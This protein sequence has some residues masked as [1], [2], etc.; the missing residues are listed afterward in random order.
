MNLKGT[1]N[2]GKLEV[3]KYMCDQNSQKEKKEM[4]KEVIADFLSK[5][6]R[7][8]KLTVL[9]SVNLQQKKYEENSTKIYN[10]QVAQENRHVDIDSSRSHVGN[11]TSEKKVELHL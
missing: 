11:N 2:C 1:M 7:N 9:S 8:Y 10:N 5:F 6:E 4:L 3:N